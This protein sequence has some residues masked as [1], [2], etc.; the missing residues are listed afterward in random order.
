[1]LSVNFIYVVLQMLT[2]T[3]TAIT[4]IT[5]TTSTTTTTTTSTTT[6]SISTTATTAC[7]PRRRRNIDDGT[8][9]T[10]HYLHCNIVTFLFHFRLF[11]FPDVD[12]PM[13]MF[14]EESFV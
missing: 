5:T 6:T 13:K 1:M 8:F 4:T 3:A 14:Q 7:I 10:P 11:Y 2:S 9:L 12:I